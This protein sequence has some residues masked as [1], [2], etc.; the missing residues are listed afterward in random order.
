MTGLDRAVGMVLPPTGGRMGG[1]STRPGL[2]WTSLVLKLCPRKPSV[3]G[4]E[5]RQ[6]PRWWSPG[7]AVRGERR[8]CKGPEA[9]R[10]QQY[11][12]NVEN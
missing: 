2:P 7:A 6:Q 10:R 1:L 5:Q 12:W 9:E 3:P 8:Q 4:P 11:G